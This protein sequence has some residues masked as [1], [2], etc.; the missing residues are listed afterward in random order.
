MSS[1]ECERDKSRSNSVRKD[2]RAI[3]SVLV[4]RFVDDIPGVDLTAVLTSQSSDVAF[5][6]G[7]QCSVV[8][9]S[10]AN[11]AGKLA[12]PN[13]KRDGSARHAYIYDSLTYRDNGHGLFG[14]GSW[15]NLLRSRHGKMRKT[16]EVARCFPI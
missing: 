7:G 6:D 14:C 13:C 12:V 2:G 16:L 4:K 3:C 1:L 8:E 10:A 9:P 5:N 11:P 15:P